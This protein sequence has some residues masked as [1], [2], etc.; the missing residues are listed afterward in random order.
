MLAL[1]SFYPVHYQD[2]PLPNHKILM[3]SLCY[4]HITSQT[5]NVPCIGI[6]FHVLLPHEVWGW[7][8]KS[9][10]H[11]R[12]GHSCLGKWIMDYG[13]MLPVKSE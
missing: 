12:F 5:L 13:E 1:K 2:S 4:R 11:I 3:L 10:M 9:C 6:V 7:D 8:E